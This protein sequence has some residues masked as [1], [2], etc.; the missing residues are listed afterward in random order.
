M[1]WHPKPAQRTIAMRHE[2][3]QDL[4]VQGAP[5]VSLVAQGCTRQQLRI[6]CARRKCPRPTPHAASQQQQGCSCQET[7]RRPHS[8][9]KT[10]AGSVSGWAF[11]LRQ[12]PQKNQ[13]GGKSGQVQCLLLDNSSSRSTS[14]ILPC[15][16]QLQSPST[17]PPTTCILRSHKLERVLEDCHVFGVQG[18]LAIK[19]PGIC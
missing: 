19:I 17:P 12:R 14:T 4:H 9:S 2:R 11:E 10:A 5:Q 1:S 15:L 7:R 6:R 16:P 18:D 8:P 13:S 3:L